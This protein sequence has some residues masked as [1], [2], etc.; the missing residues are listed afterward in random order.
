MSVTVVTCYYK[1]NSKHSHDNYDRW[2][3]NFL[4]NVSCNLVIFTS[5]DLVEYIAEKRMRFI[6]KTIIKT[7]ELEDL[8]I[9]KLYKDLWAVQYQMDNQKDTG[10]TKECY[11]IWNSKLFFLREVMESNPFFSDKFIWSDI[12]CLRMHCYDTSLMNQIIN[13]YPIYEKISKTQI[14]IVLLEPIENAE[15]KIFIGERHFSGAIF[16]GHKD[17]IMLLYE[18]FY[19][20]LYDHIQA[21]IFIGCDQQTIS[22]IYNENRELFNC[23][24]CNNHSNDDYNWFY[25]W[26]HYSQL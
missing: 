9:Y 24:S 23:I 11:V 8:P 13:N 19:K 15:Q 26:E 7:I 12:G 16:G 4:S 2:M 22:S 6:D 5:P 18:L 25:L 21:G 14:D 10:R 3:T 1:I 20:K 17:V